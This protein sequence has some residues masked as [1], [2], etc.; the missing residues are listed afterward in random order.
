MLVLIAKGFCHGKNN[1]KFREK[2]GSGWVGEAPTRIIF[3]FSDILCVFFVF[4]VVGFVLH[5][6]PKNLKKWI[7]GEWVSPI[8]VFLGLL[9][10]L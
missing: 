2:L 4:C 7:G 5:V 1:T 3:F 10:F 8:R 6:S 9:D